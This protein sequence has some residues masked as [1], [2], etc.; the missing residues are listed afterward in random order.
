MLHPRL[1][2]LPLRSVTY[3]VA[4]HFGTFTKGAAE[5][6]DCEFRAA[7]CACKWAWLDA[8]LLNRDQGRMQLHKA[9]QALPGQC[10]R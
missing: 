7:Q 4:Q 5:A 2:Q 6:L 10:T 9:M 3:K 8:R 1:L